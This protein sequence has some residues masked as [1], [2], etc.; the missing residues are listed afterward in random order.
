VSP[1]EYKNNHV[2]P[3]G[4]LSILTHLIINT[5]NL[6]PNPIS[7]LNGPHFAIRK[8]SIP[9]STFSTQAH[10]LTEKQ[11]NILNPYSFIQPPPPAPNIIMAGAYTDEQAR[12][13]YFYTTLS[14]LNSRQ[15][16][17]I[18]NQYFGTRIG[19]KNMQYAMDNIAYS[20]QYDAES[21][22]L[23]D[24]AWANPWHFGLDPGFWRH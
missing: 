2:S 14:Y 17:R 15:L 19:Y 8:A 7:N 5:Y 18:F 16:A 13:I 9:I 10:L 12:F 20:G 22:A 24:E 1:K 23:C 21:I 4:I 11:L 3:H 6:K